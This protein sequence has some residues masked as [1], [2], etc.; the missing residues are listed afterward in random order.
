MMILFWLCWV[1]IVAGRLSAV[2]VRELLVAMMSL[3]AECGL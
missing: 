2:V 1:F 3:V